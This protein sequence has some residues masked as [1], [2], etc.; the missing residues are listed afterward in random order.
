MTIP[1]CLFL[2]FQRTQAVWSSCLCFILFPFWCFF[3]FFLACKMSSH[4]KKF[5]PILGQQNSVPFTFSEI[6]KQRPWSSCYS[7]F[8]REGTY[9]FT[10]SLASTPLW[11][12]SESEA[13]PVRSTACHVR[14]QLHLRFFSC[15]YLGGKN[16]PRTMLLQ[17][18][19]ETYRATL[20]EMWFCKEQTLQPFRLNSFVPVKRV[21]GVPGLS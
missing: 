6:I 2:T 21:C 20:A 11:P 19:D 3:F 18:A 9:L 14:H 15:W 7:S 17:V 8:P 10:Q 13:S 4:Y 1:T 12:L 16:T 5:Q